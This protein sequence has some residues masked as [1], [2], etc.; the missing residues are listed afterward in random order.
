VLDYKSNFLGER[1]AD[2]APAAL[3]AAMDAHAYRFQAL[4]YSVAL[5]R[6]LRQ[7]LPGYDAGRHLGEAIYLFVRGV[8]LGP[9]AGV[10]RQRFSP[11]LLD[12]VDAVFAAAR[13]AGAEVLHEPRLWPEYHPGYYGVFFRDP[14]GNNVEAVHHTF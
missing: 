11:A 6:Y 14:D 2:Y 3:T 9:D 5:Q 12:A 8:G 13:E 7:R 1:L 4:L 10:W